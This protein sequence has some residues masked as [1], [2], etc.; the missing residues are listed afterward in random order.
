MALMAGESIVIAVKSLYNIVLR[1]LVK[2]VLHTD[3]FFALRRQY[4][5]EW[6][7]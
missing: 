2:H 6:L 7:T 1:C 4:S 3:G 5:C